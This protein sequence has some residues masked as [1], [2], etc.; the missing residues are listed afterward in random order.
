M[1]MKTPLRLPHTAIRMF[2]NRKARN[3]YQQELAEGVALN[4]LASVSVGD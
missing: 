3:S 2:K 1:Q 4:T